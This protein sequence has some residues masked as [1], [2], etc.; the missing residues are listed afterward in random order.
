M[1]KLETRVPE[2][3]PTISVVMC[4]YNSEKY[5]AQAIES[6]LEQTYTN[7]EFIIVNDAATDS[8]LDSGCSR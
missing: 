4:V 7:F 5:L 3:I 1:Q 6:I 2:Q 8:S